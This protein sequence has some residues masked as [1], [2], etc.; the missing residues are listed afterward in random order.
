MNKLDYVSA[1]VPEDCVFKISP[2]SFASFI[3][4]PWQWYRQQVQGL[5][6]FEYNTSSVIGSIV[7]YCAE[8]VALDEE[9][10][11][12][13]I[14][15]YITKHE[16]KEDY[17]QSTVAD[18]W[19]AMAVELINNYVMPEQSSILAVEKQVCAEIGN[20]IY[21][22][23]TLDLLQ[24]TKEDCMLVDYK[25]Y[26]SKTTPKAIPADYKY[27]LLVYCWI[28]RK[29]GYN[30]S[31]I[32]LVYINRNIDGGLSEKTGKPLKS[33]PPEV[34]V[35]T[36]SLVDDDLEFIESMLTLCKETLEVSD[37][38]PELRHIIWHDNRAKEE[39]DV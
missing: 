20:G 33:Y 16:E 34:T 15:D 1:S 9:V 38:H 13:A 3:G 37:K 11:E 30:V 28:L 10:D 19:Y 17:C 6:G 31:R 32:R 36:E 2:S 23:G 27:Q 14:Q 22:A 5:D 35:L 7:H 25:T 8:T 29:L 21:A 4:R 24:G 26:N 39:T 12:Q 18:N